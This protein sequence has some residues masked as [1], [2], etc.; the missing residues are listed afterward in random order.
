[1]KKIAR[2]LLV[3]LAGVLGLVAVSAGP[4]AASMNHTEPLTAP[5]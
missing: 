1:M 3:V 2:R 5:R 4:A